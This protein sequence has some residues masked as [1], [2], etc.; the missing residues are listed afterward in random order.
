MGTI[1]F[2][3]AKLMNLI[4][5]KIKDRLYEWLIILF[6]LSNMPSTFMQVT[7]QV[8]RAFL[9]KFLIFYIDDIL[10]SHP[11]RLPFSFWLQF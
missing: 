5:F 6:Q 10:E 3:S 9:G 4:I 8:W 7:S 1:K 11:R 2:V